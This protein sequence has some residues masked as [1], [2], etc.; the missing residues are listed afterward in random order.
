MKRHYLTLAAIFLSFWLLTGCSGTGT[1]VKTG[2][3]GDSGALDADALIAKYQVEQTPATGTVVGKLLPGSG[4]QVNNTPVYLAGVYWDENRKDG[5]FALDSSSSPSTISKEDGV[6]IIS[7]VN[8]GEYAIIVGEV[9]GTSVVIQDGKGNAMVI[10]VE[11]DKVL[12]LAE[13]EVK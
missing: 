11:A 8:P 9:I 7:N 2:S 12:N 4:I 10:K 3:G 13:L 6:F 1:A 5:A